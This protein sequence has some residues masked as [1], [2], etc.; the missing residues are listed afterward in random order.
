[1]RGEPLPIMTT[2]AGHLIVDLL[3]RK[4]RV[5]MEKVFSVRLLE[6]DEETQMKMLDK[7][8]KQFGHRSKKAFVSVLKTAENWTPKFS[9]MIDKI[10]SGCEGCIMVK[11][12]PDRPAVAMPMSTDFNQTVT[13]D[14]KIWKGK[15]F[16]LANLVM[17]ISQRLLLI[18]RDNGFILF[19]LH[20]PLY[21]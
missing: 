3:G 8:H 5:N 19:L 17:K 20:Y 4:Q 12:S 10:I 16:P 1:M 7:I 2:S 11:R 6:A 18:S 13:M 15:K 21:P 14:L 9:S